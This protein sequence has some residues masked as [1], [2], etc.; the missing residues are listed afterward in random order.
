MRAFLML[1]VVL[2]GCGR[3]DIGETVP[4]Q[5]TPQPVVSCKST[6]TSAPS[7]IATPLNL[8]AGRPLHWQ[9]CAG[10]VRVSYDAAL[11]PS[12]ALDLY[13]AVKAWKLAAGDSL[14]LSMDMTA[15]APLTETD[16][17]RIFVKHADPRA[18]QAS[19][20]T[21]TFDQS[22]GQMLQVQVE[23]GAS[24]PVD[25]QLAS[26]LGRALGLVTGPEGQSAVTPNPKGLTAPGS[27]DQTTLRAMYGD[28]PWCSPR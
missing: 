10:C 15:S 9:T 12:E 21:I 20:T 14:C 2:A 26:E 28:K 8:T 1:L 24:L 22:T 7:G 25:R 5:T 16:R 6:C 18:D 13:A 27:A 19:L 4:T 11:T 23:F 17:Q 3:S